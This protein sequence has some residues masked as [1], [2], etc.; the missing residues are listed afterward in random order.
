MALGDVVLMATPTPEKDRVF[1]ARW[2]ATVFRPAAWI[3]SE[4]TGVP[5]QLWY[6][7]DV[8]S[9]TLVPVP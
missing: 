5:T 7:R 2:Q 1:N 8:L 6:S 4:L 9:S 3:E